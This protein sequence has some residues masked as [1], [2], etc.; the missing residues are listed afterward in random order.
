MCLK[1]IYSSTSVGIMKRYFCYASPDKKAWK[2][3]TK[4]SGLLCYLPTWHLDEL[5]EFYLTIGWRNNPTLTD[6]LLVEV[7]TRNRGSRKQVSQLSR[8][9]LYP[10]R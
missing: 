5:V 3:K 9:H 4:I 1:E 6:R 10:F 8:D 2:E 7:G